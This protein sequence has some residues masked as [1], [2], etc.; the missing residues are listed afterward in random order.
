M[1]L[2]AA[3]NNTHCV[4]SVGHHDYRSFENLMA[5][6]G[7]PDLHDYGRY[8]RFSGKV[9]W[10]DLPEVSFG[11]LYNDYQQNGP[12]SS[13][14]RKYGIHKLSEVRILEESEY[15]DTKSF[16][17]QRD[18]AIWGTR[19]KNGDEP[20]RYVNLVNCDTEHLKNIKMYMTG[21]SDDTISKY[22]TSILIE[23]KIADITNDGN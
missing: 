23:R 1:K 5:D 9:C 11:E 4:F 17:W 15:P 3:K 13:T 2:L 22:I 7:Q 18:N 12:H 19:G 14:P 8:N 10:I 20:L 6:G 21:N 16:E